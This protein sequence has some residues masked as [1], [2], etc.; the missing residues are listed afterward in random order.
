MFPRCMMALVALS[1]ACGGDQVTRETFLDRWMKAYREAPCTA[2]VSAFRYTS[3]DGPEAL[4]DD[5]AFDADAAEACVD[6]ANWSCGAE[7]SGVEGT[8]PIPPAICLD[9]CP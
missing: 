4:P 2:N 8:L 9:V 3:Q 5:C 7:Q 6:P 1:S